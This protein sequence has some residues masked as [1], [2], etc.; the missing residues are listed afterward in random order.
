MLTGNT[1]MTE[2]RSSS[3][4]AAISTALSESG[5]GIVRIS[6]PEAVTV[7]DRVFRSPGGKTH[8][9]EVPSHTIHYGY[10]VDSDGEPVDE[11]LVSVMRA[12]KTYT[13]E[14][15]VEINCHGGVY[16]V[17]RVL[18]TV[19]A[20]GARMAEP[21]EFTKR[22]FL[23][24]RIDLSRA[25]AVMDVIG[26]KNRFALKN[27]LSQVRGSLYEKIST[28]R[29]EILT[30]TARIEAALDDPEHLSLDGCA[31][32]L[33]KENQRWISELDG[34]ISSFENGRMIQDGIR[35]VIVGKPNAGKS[36]LLN[37]LLGEERA[38]VTD[39]A[40]TTRDVITEYANLDGITL[41]IT[42]TAGI[43]DTDDP[44]EKIGVDR[45]KKSLED[46]DLVLFVLDTSTSID[47]ND[48]DVLL[49]IRNK[50]CI[51][52][53]NKSDLPQRMD[54][55][56]IRK[57]LTEEAD[58]LFSASCNGSSDS[59]L[60][61]NSLSTLSTDEQARDSCVNNIVEKM[62]LILFSV[63]N[64]T[65]LRELTDTIRQMFFSG[66]LNDR[67]GVVITNAR[68]KELLVDARESLLRLSDSIRGQMSEDF[69]TIDLTGAYESLGELIGEETGEDLINEIFS[70]FC[71]GK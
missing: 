1:G 27:A 45:A 53:A 37:L 58:L 2:F 29:S 55:T 34:L 51:L 35:T 44:V 9:S 66:K 32:T 49:S 40:G 16:A 64:Q 36:S 60:P 43:R 5:I 48:L 70:K 3:T 21:G 23:N 50:P 14:D 42:D 65:G 54:E 28:L 13:A 25:E 56:E 47:K 52:I 11:V 63:Y 69:F 24:G 6:G 4:I 71:M 41:M 19:L 10:L 22:A 17:R 26:S 7:G 31:D 8:L 15:V 59:A 57:S 61:L 38:I 33:E 30:A 67:E 20:H 18:E 39:I 62:P 68:Q 12:P 46:A